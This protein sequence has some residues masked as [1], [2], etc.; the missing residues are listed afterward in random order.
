MFYLRK[1]LSKVEDRLSPDMRTAR[2]DSA[3]AYSG[4]NRYSVVE[5][6]CGKSEEDLLTSIEV[7]TILF[8]IGR[9]LMNDEHSTAERYLLTA[10][11]IGYPVAS[12]QDMELMCDIQSTLGDLYINMF[13]T[14]NADIWY[15]N[16]IKTASEMTGLTD[17]V[18]WPARATCTI[19]FMTPFLMLSLF[20]TKKE[21]TLGS[22][23]QPVSLCAHGQ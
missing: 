6:I 2:T 15:K 11:K 8:H 9:F 21:A 1:W 13:D 5:K 22:V 23:V 20:Q 7:A 17:K 14:N 19:H 3:H 16:A 18:S 10:Y 12:V 4:I